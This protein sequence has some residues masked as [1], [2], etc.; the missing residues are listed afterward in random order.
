MSR[1]RLLVTDIVGLIFVVLGTG[2]F[3]MTRVH[4]T[5][6]IATV[7]GTSSWWLVRSSAQAV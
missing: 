5:I 2:V 6:T 4:L 3:W 1:R 7:Q